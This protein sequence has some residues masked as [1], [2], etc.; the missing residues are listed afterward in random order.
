MK[1]LVRRCGFLAI[2]VICLLVLATPPIAGQSG[3]AKGEWPSY[4]ADVANTRYSPLDPGLDVGPFNRHPQVA[5]ADVEQ[6]I[7]GKRCP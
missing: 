2:P 3:T 1:P 5:H 7:V 6:T 4:G